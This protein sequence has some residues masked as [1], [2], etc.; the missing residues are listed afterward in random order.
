VTVVIKFVA[1]TPALA[2]LIGPGGNLYLS[3]SAVGEVV[4]F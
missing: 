3:R 1:A 2:Q 4:Y